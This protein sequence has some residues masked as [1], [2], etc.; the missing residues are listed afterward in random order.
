MSKHTPGPW[1]YTP[2]DG[3]L[4]DVYSGDGMTRW[5]VASINSLRDGFDANARLI[6]ACPD[7]LDALEACEMRLTHLAQDG[8]QVTHELKVAR[9]ALSKARGHHREYHAKARGES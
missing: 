9:A 4:P 2:E 6:A 1:R 5:N 3:R 7:L 8:A